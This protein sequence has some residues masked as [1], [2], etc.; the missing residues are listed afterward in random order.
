MTDM[1]A[2]GDLAVLTVPAVASIPAGA[3]TAPEWEALKGRVTAVEGLG[4]VDLTDVDL[5]GLT[6][7][8]TVVYHSASGTWKPGTL[9]GTIGAVRDHT[10]TV[11][12]TNADTLVFRLGL[13]AV[14]VVLS[15]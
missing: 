3:I 9:T 15:P 2:D 11:V 14:H 10:A 4:L 7:G 6:D 12:K 1:Y 13:T 5:T 8:L